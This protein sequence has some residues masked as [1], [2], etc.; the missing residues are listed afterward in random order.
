MV[1][2]AVGEKPPAAVVVALICLGGDAADGF[3]FHQFAC[4]FRFFEAF[5]ENLGFMVGAGHG[6]Y[7]SLGLNEVADI[8][9]VD[10]DWF[11]HL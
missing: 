3:L 5:L 7:H 4:Q 9:V 10:R 8:L 1:L 11:G 6:N 2:V